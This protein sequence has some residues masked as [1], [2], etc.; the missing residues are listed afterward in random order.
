MPGTVIRVQAAIGD[1][2]QPGQP[3]VVIEAMKMEHMIT[4]PAAGLLAGVQ[5]AVGDQVDAGTVLALVDEG[6]DD[7]AT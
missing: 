6:D 2:V 3:I 1:Q 4:A 7:G 5:V